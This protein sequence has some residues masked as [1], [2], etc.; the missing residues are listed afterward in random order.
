MVKQY[1]NDSE[2]WPPLRIQ[3]I[4]LNVNA[5]G[6]PGSTIGRAEAQIGTYLAMPKAVNKTPIFR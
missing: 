5:I 2:Y 6:F 1:G 4:D 3:A